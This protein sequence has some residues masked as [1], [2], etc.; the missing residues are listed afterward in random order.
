MFHISGAYNITVP[1]SVT[2]AHVGNDVALS[3][4]FELQGCQLTRHH[5]TL[6]WNH[7]NTVVKNDGVKYYVVSNLTNSTSIISQLT[8]RNVNNSD[9]GNYTCKLLGTKLERRIILNSELYS[10]VKSS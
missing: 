7:T 4:Y 1:S 2:L 5:T 6:Q 8:I 3:C 9:K 10:N